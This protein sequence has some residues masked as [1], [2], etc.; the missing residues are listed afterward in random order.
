MR[1]HREHSFLLND[2]CSTIFG[3]TWGA[4]LAQIPSSETQHIGDNSVQ[5]VDQSKAHKLRR[6]SNSSPETSISERPAVPNAI[7]S[8]A[9]FSRGSY[10]AGQISVL[11][12]WYARIRGELT[13]RSHSAYTDQEMLDHA[14]VCAE[15]LSAVKAELEKGRYRRRPKL[16]VCANLLGLADRELVSLYPSAMLRWRVQSVRD[17]LS[18]MNPVPLLEVERL[19]RLIASPTGD[20]QVRRTA[21]KDALAYVHGCDKQTILEDDL[22]VTRLKRLLQ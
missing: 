22:Q 4:E 17:N 8:R 10:S 21:L 9:V 12:S 15:T 3:P 14:L 5:L 16:S 2:V 20:E 19:D 1:G 6:P 11:L 18:V 13:V 7:D